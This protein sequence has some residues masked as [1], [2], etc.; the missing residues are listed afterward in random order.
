MQ[1]TDAIKGTVAAVL[2]L[3]VLLT[4]GILGKEHEVTRWTAALSII[5]WLITMIWMNR[6]RKKSK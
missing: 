4:F 3:A 6:I 5:I 1:K 2:I